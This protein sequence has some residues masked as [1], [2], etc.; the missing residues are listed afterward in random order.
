MCFFSTSIN[1]LC[2]AL[3]QQLNLQHPLSTVSTLPPPCLIHSTWSVPLTSSFLILST[4]LL[5]S[6][7]N[8]LDASSLSFS[9]TWSSVR[10]IYTSTFPVFIISASSLLYK[11]QSKLRPTIEPFP[12][13]ACWSAPTPVL[14][15]VSSGI[16]RSSM[17]RSF[18]H[19]WFG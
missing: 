19:I 18:L 9:S 11:S 17:E 14:V 10:I 8:R 2:G 7:S 13:G 4:P 6:W 12:M 3:T 1:L 15:V 5:P 16:N